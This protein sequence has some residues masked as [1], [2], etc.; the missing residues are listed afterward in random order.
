MTFVVEGV[1]RQDDPDSEVR[2]VGEY[3]TREEAIA[4]AKGMVDD[5]L[6]REHKTGMLPSALFS[7][8]QERGEHPFIFRDADM[9]MNVRT[10]DHLQYAM[11]RSTEI[12]GGR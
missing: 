9:T 11:L 3:E 4:A 2:R 10:F 8:Y 7:L 6:R 1:L 5:F 12:C